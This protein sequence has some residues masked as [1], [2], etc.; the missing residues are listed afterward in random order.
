MKQGWGASALLLVLAGCGS[1]GFP[2]DPAALGIHPYPNQAGK[3]DVNGEKNFAT[4]INNYQNGQPAKTPLVGY[5]WPYTANGIAS[6]RN[7]G[8]QSPAGK[9]DAARGIGPNGQRYNSQAWEVQH[10][11]AGVPRVEGWWGHC[12]GWCAAAALYDEPRAPVRYGNINFSVGDM[13]ALYSEAGMLTSADFYGNRWDYNTDPDYKKEDIVPNQMFLVLTNYMGNLKLPVLMDRYTGTQ[14]WNQPMVAYQM[15]YPK[16]EDYIGPHPSAPGVYRINVTTTIW[17]G[18]D[19]VG[20]DEITEPFEF[21]QSRQFT[22]RTLKSELWLDGPVVFNGTRVVSS[23]NLIVT[24]IPNTDG[25]VGGAWLGD[26]NDSMNGHPDYLWVPFSIL[27]ANN[28]DENNPA[29]D[30]ANNQIDL[31]WF[32]RHIIGGEPDTT[33]TPIPVSTAPAPIA[34]SSPHPIPAPQPQPHPPRP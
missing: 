21:R 23:G 8:G 32:R 11:G 2:D 33:A 34:T 22:P 24:R 1:A 9:Y 30:F 15:E 12:N 14:V 7:G 17:W 20:A 26:A 25:V 6:G 19:G 29:D 3:V 28:P 18:E 13:K 27:N 31:G 16:P 5:W 10:H 4:L